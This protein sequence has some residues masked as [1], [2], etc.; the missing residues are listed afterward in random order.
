MEPN[1][2]ITEETHRGYHEFA[3]LFPLLQGKEFDALKDDISENGLLEAIWLHPGDESIIDGRN[4]HRACIETETQPHFRAWG[5]E[6][7]LVAF[8]I[9]MN[10]HRRHLTSGQRAAIAV[11]VLPM[12]ETEAKER[13]RRGGQEKV[14]QKFVGP[15]HAGLAAQQ[16]AELLNTNRQYVSDAKRLWQDAPELFEQI[17]AGDKTISQAKRELTKRLRRETPPLPSD[18]YRIIYADPPWRYGNI[19]PDEYGPAERH[20]PTMSITELCE[21]GEQIEEIT[22]DNAVLFLWVT[23]PLLAECFPV[24]RAWGFKYKTSFV[25]D[26]VGHNFGHYNSV[27]H[28]L[29]L[30]CTKGSC[31]PDVSK[32]FDS[33]QS[34]EKSREHSEKPEQ[35]REIIDTLYTHGKRIELFSR[36]QVPGWEMWGNEP[37]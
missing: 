24:I 2:W 33:V 30:V 8:I 35:F 10:L 5:G 16:A 32:L 4:R 18:K 21:L 1:D 25:W 9:S 36:T 6:G 13:Q 15:T 34:I 31:T 11:E 7:S 22:D 14:V 27:R 26:K 28:E 19:G 17:R 3:N 37:I 23:S 12:L 20:Y 29:L